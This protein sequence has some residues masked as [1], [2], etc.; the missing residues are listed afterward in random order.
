[1]SSVE[2][3]VQTERTPTW[4]HGPD[5][6]RVGF[7]VGSLS[8]IRLLSGLVDIHDTM[9]LG[10]QQALFFVVSNKDSTNTLFKTGSLQASKIPAFRPTKQSILVEHNLGQVYPG[11]N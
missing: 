2:N 3:V 9:W 1:M 8:A 4:V 6:W 11:G 10:H 5:L 7:H